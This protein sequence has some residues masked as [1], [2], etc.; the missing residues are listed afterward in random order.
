MQSMIISSSEVTNSQLNLPVWQQN[1]CLLSWKV[2][3][4]MPLHTATLG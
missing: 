4:V 3:D 1:S 2:R